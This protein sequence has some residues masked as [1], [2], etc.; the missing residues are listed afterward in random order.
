MTGKLYGVGVSVGDPELLT[1]KAIRVIKECDIIAIPKEKK[2]ECIAW[3]I[4]E[5]VIDGIDEKPI[6]PIHMPMT[7]D[8]TLLEE[9]HM[10]G[11]RLIAEQL[12]QGKNIAFLTIGDPCVYATYMYVHKIIAKRSFETEIISGVTSFC[13][14]A[15]A[16]NIP[17]CEED[18]ELHIIPSSYG[19]ENA[20]DYKGVKVIM[21]G[22]SKLPQIV[23]EINKKSQNT[24]IDVYMVENCGMK[25]QKVY[26]SLEQ[27]LQKDMKQ[28]SYYTT[29]IIKEKKDD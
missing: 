23:Q 12:Q 16:I 24:P 5:K 28:I 18:Q 1:L 20:L 10:E 17:L 19:I 11:A 26:G 6:L 7:K 9:S 4:V 25:D 22:A 29:M 15:A 27:I 2:E 14:A 13:A 3:Q 8:K 21:K